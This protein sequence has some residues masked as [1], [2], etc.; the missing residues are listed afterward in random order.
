M[1]IILQVKLNVD[2]DRNDEDYVQL[3]FEHVMIEQ[4]LKEKLIKKKIFEKNF[5]TFEDL[6]LYLLDE[7]YKLFVNMKI[8]DQ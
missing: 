8:I 7:I 2:V 5:F 6:I 1:M 4:F 3:V